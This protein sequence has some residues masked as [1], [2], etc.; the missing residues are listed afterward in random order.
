MSTQAASSHPGAAVAPGGGDHLL[1]ELCSTPRARRR[2]HITVALALYALAW[3]LAL[4]RAQMKHAPI[5]LV[6]SDAVGSYAYLPSVILDGDLSFENQLRAQFRGEIPTDYVS[7][8]QRANR[9]PIGV[10]LSL[11]PAFLVAH[12][13]SHLLGG[14][15]NGYSAVYMIF[16]LAGAMSLACA[17]LII[18]DRFIVERFAVPG[19][20]AAAAV[21]TWWLGTN[22]VWFWLREPFIAHLIGSAWAVFTVFHIHRADLESRDGALPW[23]RIPVVI[24]CAAMLIV[25]RFSNVFVAPLLVWLVFVLWR[26]QQL[27]ALVRQLP[28]VLLAAFP[29]YL[30]AIALYLMH[31]HVVQDSVQSIGYGQRERFY[32]TDPALVLSLFSSRRGLF[33]WTPAL[34]LSAFGLI[35][36]TTRRAGWRDGLLISLVISAGV[37]WYINASWYAW[38]LGNSAGN[39]GYIE[40]APL[41]IAGFGCAYV[42]LTQ[43]SAALR[44]AVIA[45]I[46]IAVVA[47]YAVVAGKLL[48]RLEGHAPLI[49]WESG[50]QKGPWERF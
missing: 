40:L 21:L 39:R 46:A 45:F 8:T 42:W 28:L 16:C 22:Y 37:L 3:M 50:W 23:W 34:L 10:A 47:N 24:F 25:C 29:L 43:T 13:A 36:Q 19:T 41:W 30:Q 49:P 48:D 12:G 18:A 6:V 7:I 9:W 27:R 4:V 32:W 35:W 31:G 11:A 44:R 5:E 17:S 1:G 26:R 15:P 2:L 33:F 14:E 20:C 38:W